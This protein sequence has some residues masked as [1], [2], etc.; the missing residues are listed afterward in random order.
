M[1]E[2]DTMEQ[3]T[4]AMGAGAGAVV[5]MGALAGSAP[6]RVPV[7][8]AFIRPRPPSF[9]MTCRRRGCIGFS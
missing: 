3:D 8:R 4:Q 5:V 7:P 9:R 6:M 1:V 2:V